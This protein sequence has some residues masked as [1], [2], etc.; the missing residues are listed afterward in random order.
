MKKYAII[1]IACTFALSII[2]FKFSKKSKI[3]SPEIF[4]QKVTLLCANFGKQG[5]KVINNTA[6][7]NQLFSNVSPS[8]SCA[9]YVPEAIDFDK[10]TLVGVFTSTAGCKNP[11]GEYSATKDSETGEVA[12]NVTITQSGLCKKMNYYKIWCIIP[13]VND[14]NKINFIIIKK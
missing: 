1:F 3:D 8:S 13:K 12:F 6:E 11:K 5:N 2:S 10:Y 9:S 4:C 7:Y 14:P